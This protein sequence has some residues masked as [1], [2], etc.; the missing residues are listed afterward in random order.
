MLSHCGNPN[1]A[2]GINLACRQ[3]NQLYRNLNRFRIRSLNELILNETHSFTGFQ[4]RQSFDV[5]AMTARPQTTPVKQMEFASSER[6]G[7]MEIESNTST[8]KQRWNWLD[9]IWVLHEHIDSNANMCSYM[10]I[11]HFCTNRSDYEFQW[12]FVSRPLRYQPYLSSRR[13]PSHP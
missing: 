11:K 2:I 10:V 6:R 5:T 13:L 1:W 12:R 7:L 9:R 8:G 3:F 4:I